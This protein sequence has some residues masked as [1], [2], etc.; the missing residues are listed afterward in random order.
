MSFISDLAN[1]VIKTEDIT[2]E[3]ALKLACSSDLEELLEN[4]DK[5]RK[6]FCKNNFNLCSI[7]N[8]KSGKCSENCKYCAQSAHF[9]TNSPNYSLLSDDIIF[10]EALKFEEKGVHRFSLVMSG[11][12]VKDNSDELN[13]LE[14]IYKYLTK[15]SKIHLCGSF[16]IV[17]LETLK[18][19]KNAG[20][21]TYHH[22]LETSRR[23]FPKI[24][25]THTYDDRINTIKNAKLAGLD[26]CSGAIFG[27][28]ENLEDRI[29]LAFDLKK[30]NVS[31]VPLNILTPIKGTPLENLP[32]LPKD[33][34]LKSIAIFR[35]ILPKAYLRYA[36]GRNNL[37]EFVE[38][39]LKG[40]INSALTGDFLTTKGDGVE[41]DKNMVLKNGFEI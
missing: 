36:G 12:G 11:K 20:L 9:K 35:F 14:E 15:N 21:K 6:H 38:T 23:F 32:P 18:K 40:G 28:G 41:S 37:G 3:D 13:R 5:I 25:S 34:I 27:M 31:S 2:K 4:A 16:G 39:G 29:N 7:I 8:A 19:L 22:N 10:K 33:E 24:C 30:L 1:S 26:V 17:G